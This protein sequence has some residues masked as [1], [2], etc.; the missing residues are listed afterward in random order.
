MAGSA[1]VRA[2]AASVSAMRRGCN[3]RTGIMSKYILDGKTPVKC[4]N[5]LE[6]ARW[7]ETADR[8]VA[9]TELNGARVSTV[10]LSLSHSFGEGE[11]LLF[12]TMVFGGEHD[13]EMTRCS[14]WEQ[15]EEMHKN[16]VQ[17]ISAAIAQG[18][19]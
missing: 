3:E 12:E 8:S 19:K 15:A 17:L 10:F 18:E 11:P 16:M 14:T 6:W 5:T 1:A 4:N 9:F 13:G 2:D 7:Y